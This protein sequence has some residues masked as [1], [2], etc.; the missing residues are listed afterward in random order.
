M[1]RIHFRHE[2][3]L[4]VRGGFGGRDTLRI[5]S[6]AHEVGLLRRTSGARGRVA[7]RT[8]L[9]LEEGL[10]GSSDEIP[11]AVVPER[12]GPELRGKKGKKKGRPSGPVPIT[13]SSSVEGDWGTLT[14]RT[15]RLDSSLLS[16]GGAPCLAKSE[17]TIRPCVRP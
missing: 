5:A 14:P 13:S 4:F 16:P 1:R 15:V 17:I 7:P 2:Y 11:R 9:A 3:F 12:S 8:L 10:V 6:R